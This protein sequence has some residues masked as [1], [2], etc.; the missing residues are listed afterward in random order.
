MGC[1][2]GKAYDSTKSG[3]DCAGAACTVGECCKDCVTQNVVPVITNTAD[4]ATVGTTS[5]V[6]DA[7]TNINVGMAVSSNM[8]GGLFATNTRVVM[9]AIEGA[10]P[11][12]T[13]SKPTTA[14]VLSNAPVTLTFEGAA[15]ASEHAGACVTSLAA[16]AADADIDTTELR[17]LVPHAGYFVD[18]TGTAQPYFSTCGNT[19]G[20][21]K[22]FTDE[23][24]GP[25][26]IYDG[27]KFANSCEGTTCDDSADAARC[28]KPAT[29]GNTGDGSPFTD[30]DCGAGY[31][32]DTAKADEPCTGASEVQDK[33]CTDEQNS[34]DGTVEQVRIEN[35]RNL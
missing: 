19:D 7:I 34:C 12:V 10:K 4:A 15:C 20:Y 13:L 9:A 31:L 24:C 5:L 17:C 16:T 8:A 35:E 29:C 14:S 6:V 11:T 28:C 32:Y 26:Q 3:V 33:C 30:Q 21:G 1:G 22:L 23:A 2:P 27:A 25:G 18:A